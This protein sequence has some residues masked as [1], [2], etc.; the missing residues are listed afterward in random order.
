[1]RC[2]SVMLSDW[3]LQHEKVDNEFDSRRK[4]Y[5]VFLVIFVI[6]FLTTVGDV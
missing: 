4:K 6:C 3:Y 2:I 1:M 5:F